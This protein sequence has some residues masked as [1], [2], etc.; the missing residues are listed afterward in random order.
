VA[1]CKGCGRRIDFVRS[2]ASG[3]R[4]PLDPKPD[5]EAGTIRITARPD[6]VLPTAVVLSGQGLDQARHFG[7]ELY[8]S[9]F[10]TCPDAARFRRKR[11]KG[12]KGH[13]TY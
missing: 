6:G 1:Q 7:D 5:P 12:R 13:S 2:E 10:A 8:V 9:H 4:I 3:K 11:G